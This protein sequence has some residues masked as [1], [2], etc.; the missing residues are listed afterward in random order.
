MVVNLPDTLINAVQIQLPEFSAISIYNCAA[1]AW[2]KYG[3]EWLDWVSDFVEQ[4]FDE[5]EDYWDA[6]IDLLEDCKEELQAHFESILQD[7][8]RG[9]YDIEPLEDSQTAVVWA[10]QEDN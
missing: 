5:Y 8:E 6:M 1:G 3:N 10:K 9:L 4:S 7:D 2:L